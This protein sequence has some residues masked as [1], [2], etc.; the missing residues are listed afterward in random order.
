MPKTEFDVMIK[1]VFVALNK[2][3]S[4]DRIFFG[5]RVG[6]NFQ[7]VTIDIPYKNYDE[8][9]TVACIEIK[10]PASSGLRKCLKNREYSNN[11]FYSV[12]QSLG[13]AKANHCLRH[14]VEIQPLCILTDGEY[15]AFLDP[16]LSTERNIDIILHCPVDF[17][18]PFTEKIVKNVFE[19]FGDINVES[20]KT[21]RSNNLRDPRVIARQYSED[22]CDAKLAENLIR[23]FNK[24]T[25]DKVNGKLAIDYTMQCLLLAILR[26]CGYIPIGE[27]DENLVKKEN[28]KWILDTLSRWFDGNFEK[29]DKR[30]I[31]KFIN[32]YNSTRTYEV[33]VDAMPQE[34]LGYAY[35]RFIKKA[36]KTKKTEYY[37]PDNLIQDV[38]KEVNPTNKDII[39]D[40]TCGC[41]SFLVTIVRHIFPRYI[42][43]SK[44]MNL[45][46]KFISNN[47]FGNDRDFYAT[48]I[49]KASLLS[50]YVERL[51]IDPSEREN[52]SLPQVKNNFYIE[53]FFLF[54]WIHKKK[55]TLVVGNAPWGDV[56]SDSKNFEELVR[57]KKSWK[58]IMKIRGGVDN[59]H[60]ISGSIVLKCLDDYAHS[61]KFRLGMLVKQQ[62]LVKGKDKFLED[63]RTKNCYFF[64]YGPSALFAHTRSLTATAFFPKENGNRKIKRKYSKPFNSWGKF[65]DNNA[66]IQSVNQGAQTGKNDIWKELACEPDLDEFCIEVIDRANHKIPLQHPPTKKLV[67]IE[68]PQRYLSK[69]KL[70]E[71]EKILK[72]KYEQKYKLI[73]SK[74]DI[75]QKKRLGAVTT[76]AKSKKGEK[77]SKSDKNYIYTWRRPV[78]TSKFEKNW[79][80]IFPNQFIIN[81]RLPVFLTKQKVIGIT[82]HTQMI[83]HEN[84]TD[85]YAVNFTAW[86]SSIPFILYLEYLS[87]KQEV[88]RISGGFELLPEYVE[89]ISIPLSVLNSKEIFEHTN[90]LINGNLVTVEEIEEIDLKVMKALGVSEDEINEYLKADLERLA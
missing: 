1:K 73:E 31:A 87:S 40:P 68:P 43:S 39:F 25:K 28:K 21:L 88:K 29:V 58:K 60:E 47:V 36:N 12:R 61:K 48:N 17:I 16:E 8:M 19:K 77:Y 55:P 84:T 14:G 71:T 22:T 2:I 15:I 64:D 5:K 78:D 46:K 6:N 70:N 85:M 63:R 66:I 34:A 41:G 82:S 67:Y 79:R 81:D 3:L 38:I 65:A 45:L 10:K 44:E 52:V 53:D 89:K 35:E 27:I 9:R 7:D 86:M 30:H 51:G 42:Y 20:L 13:Y 80:I 23:T 59:R 4:A 54:E 69:K 90:P 76:G 18:F 49:A 62:I 56:S 33:R 32:A 74:L 26:N 83:L 37:T 72:Y 75:G 50:F 24:L 57:T 11:L